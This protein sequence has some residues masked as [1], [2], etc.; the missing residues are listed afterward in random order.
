VLPSGCLG[1]E[2]CR[3]EG[4]SRVEAERR[5]DVVT[6]MSTPGTVGQGNCGESQVCRL[7]NRTGGKGV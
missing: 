4:A 1:G 7:R 5:I 6:R 2:R 3:V